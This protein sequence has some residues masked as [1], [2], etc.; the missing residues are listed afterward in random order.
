MYY[1]AVRPMILLCSILQQERHCLPTQGRNEEDQEKK[2][3]VQVGRKEMG[4]F[5]DEIQAVRDLGH[6]APDKWYFFRGS[7][8][9]VAI[10]C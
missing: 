9:L 5:F 7:S 8:A 10:S 3:D 4:R 6:H 1:L 2:T